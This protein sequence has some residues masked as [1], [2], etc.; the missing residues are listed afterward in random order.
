MRVY[1]VADV[2]TPEP[3]TV[4]DSTNLE[5]AAR[6]LLRLKVRAVLSMGPQCIHLTPAA[7]ILC[8]ILY[9]LWDVFCVLYCER[10]ALRRGQQISEF[11][12]RHTQIR[13][14]PVVDEEAA[15]WACSRAAMSSAR[16][17]ACAARRSRRA[18]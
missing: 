13:R 3:F 4:R 6:I 8:I 16:R 5:A 10:V 11:A 2:M 14:L 18:S 7:A 17:C 9:S 1:R 12:Q 15:W